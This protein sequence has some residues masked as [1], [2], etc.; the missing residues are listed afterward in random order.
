MER[1]LYPECHQRRKTLRW[2]D[3]SDW[4]VA[5]SFAGIFQHHG[6]TANIVIAEC[7]VGSY[8]QFGV[9]VAGGLVILRT[10]DFQPYSTATG[11]DV[12]LY[13]RDGQVISRA[14]FT[15]CYHETQAGTGYLI[16]GASGDGS[17]SFIKFDGVWQEPA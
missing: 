11:A 16:Q 6:Q 5:N 9:D 10:I 17:F 7:V 14:T 12:C 1:A 13:P 3:R 2:R 8:F 15:D 4:R